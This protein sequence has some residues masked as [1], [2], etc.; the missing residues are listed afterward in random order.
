MN[1][2]EKQ[3]ILGVKVRAGLLIHYDNNV[4]Y[5]C[6][7]TI[8]HCVFDPSEMNETTVLMNL[9]KR[10]DQ[11]LV[12][13]RTFSNMPMELLISSN[14]TCIC[15]DPVPFC[16]LL[17]SVFVHTDLH[18]QHPLVGESLQVAQHLRHRHGASVRRPRA[19]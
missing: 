1:V 7:L 6:V 2:P 17:L 8:I 16:P 12:Y 3:L 19:E 10:Y 5:K 11:E 15:S 18:R 4:L 14:I 13:V 9:K